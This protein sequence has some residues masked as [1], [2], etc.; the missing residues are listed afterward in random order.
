MHKDFILRLAKGFRGRAKN[1]IRIARNKVEKAL[2]YQTRDRKTK[3]RDFRELWIQRINAGTREHGV[4]QL[5]CT[6]SPSQ[7]S[8]QTQSIAI[9]S[10]Y[11]SKRFPAIIRPVHRR[12]VRVLTLLLPPPLNFNRCMAFFRPPT[13]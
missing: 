6:L 2:Q 4:S 3:K 1:C 12:R 8:E 5:S 11:C 10:L 7:R 9:N 13:K